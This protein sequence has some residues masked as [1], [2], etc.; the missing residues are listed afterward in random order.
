MLIPLRCDAPL[1]HGP[2]GTIGVIACCIILHV[3]VG[4]SDAIVQWLLVFGDWNPI[5][6]LSSVLVHAGWMHLIGNMIFFWVFGLIVE[7]KVGWWRFLL[8]VVAI[9]LVSGAIEQTV[10]ISSFGA[11][12]GLSG[13]IFGLIAVAWIWA[14]ENE[15][16]V[17]L[18]LFPFIKHFAVQ[19]RT[20]GLLYLGLELLDAAL[21]GFHM[22]TPMLHLLGV[23]AGIPVGVVMLR[24]HWVDCEGW[25]WFS[26][27]ER[28]GA[29]PT[30]PNAVRAPHVPAPMPAADVDELLRSGQT[31]AAYAAWT[32]HPTSTSNIVAFRLTARLVDEQRWDDAGV[33]AKALLRADAN[34]VP[35]RLIYAW[36]L[37]QT[38]R[39]TSALEQ[40]DGLDLQHGPDAG[41]LTH[42]RQEAERRKAENPYELA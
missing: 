34:H 36:I 28:R 13:V 1:Y 21:H 24:K 6:W 22:S 17:L 38:G 14:P 12:L 15:V 32:R 20:L 42:I 8:V 9:A 7:G 25:D 29:K 18:F 19:V 37:V 3:T 10:M 27:R 41:K 11:S 40:L 2:W 31:A 26:R 33:V 4:S 39:P 16:D 5:Q 30:K 23:A 35:T